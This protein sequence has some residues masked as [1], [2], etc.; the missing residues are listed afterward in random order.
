MQVSL[1]DAIETT[2]RPKATAAKRLK[3]ARHLYL[4]ETA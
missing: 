3:A 1:N 4:A 2:G